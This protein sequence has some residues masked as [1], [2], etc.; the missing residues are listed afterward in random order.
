MARLIA[1]ILAVL[2]LGGATTLTMTEQSGETVTAKVNGEQIFIN[3]SRGIS[4]VTRDNFGRYDPVTNTR[5]VRGHPGGYVYAGLVVLKQARE[6][7]EMVRLICDKGCYSA[8]T[9][10]L[11]A[12][13]VCIGPNARFGFHAPTESLLGFRKEYDMVTVV[14]DAY[15]PG[16][17]EMFLRKWQR[18]YGIGMYVVSGDEVR[19]LSGIPLCEG[20]PA[21][22]KVINRVEENVR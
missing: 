15:P 5:T 9:L 19:R 16:I 22:N 11:G 20:V 8:A 21:R 1:Y 3:D 14:A 2:L 6:R 4:V 7:N 10:L 13:R 18:R 17:R 12:K